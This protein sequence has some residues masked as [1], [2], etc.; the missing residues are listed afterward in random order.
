MLQKT[1]KQ[2]QQSFI[3]GVK[4]HQEKALHASNRL[5]LLISTSAKEIPAY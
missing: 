2:E 1:K 3:S 4:T 5:P